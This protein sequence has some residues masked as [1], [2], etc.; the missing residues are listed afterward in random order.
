MSSLEFPFP[1]SFMDGLPTHLKGLIKLFSLSDLDSLIANLKEAKIS[2]NPEKSIKEIVASTT[3]YTPDEIDDLSKGIMRLLIITSNSDT[4]PSELIDKLFS[5]IPEDEIEKLD[6]S[7]EKYI[8][9]KKKIV[10]ILNSENLL[11]SV[12]AVGIKFE[13]DNLFERARIITQILPI[14][15]D[16]LNQ[17]P[18][19]AMVTHQLGIHYFQDGE[20]K[21]F[22]LRI[23]EDEIDDFIKTLERAKSKGN[24]LQKFLENTE[25]QYIENI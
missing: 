9:V 12:K 13:Q 18:K 22:F 6:L 11:I 19:V 14:F 4:S 25:V 3:G 21:E 1:F 7:K 2:I 5:D 24:S 20:H 16:D 15:S 10:E 23:D 17:L 8:E